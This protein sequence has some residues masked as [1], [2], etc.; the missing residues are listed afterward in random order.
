MRYTQKKMIS[1]MALTSVALFVVLAISGPV[2]GGD[3]SV[4]VHARGHAEVSETREIVLGGPLAEIKWAPVSSSLEL[5]SIRFALT[6]KAATPLPVSDVRVEDPCGGNRDTLLRRYVGK[7]I[8]LV[9]PETGDEVKGTLL[10]VDK[11]RPGMLKTADGSLHLNPSGE[12]VLPPDPNLVSQPILV[13]RFASP[14]EGKRGVQLTYRTGGLKWEPLYS[15]IFDEKTGKVDL[16]GTLILSNDTKIGFE[17]AAWRFFSTEKQKVDGPE[18]ARLDKVIEFLP[19][20]PADRQSLPARSTLRLPLL[21]ARNLPVAVAY[22]FDPLAS[23]PRVD[24][25]AQKLQR[26]IFVDN[27][28]ADN[29]LGLGGSLPSGKAKVVLRHL[30]GYTEPLGEQR[31]DSVS[32]GESVQVALGAAE[33]L[34]GKRS[35]TPF[36]ELADER[37]QEQVITIRLQNNTKSDVLA[38]VFEH[39]WGRWEIPATSSEYEQIDN[40][41]IRFVLPVP[42]TGE[43]EITYR[44]RI[45]Y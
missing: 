40:K 44:L 43:A 5:D 29:A 31:V 16:S 34:M 12:I 19:L 30:S 33:G 15:I 17:D 3:L 27:S 22:V 8:R 32:A 4:M 18:R 36:V 45:K 23:G 39:P 28:D 41:T 20:K 35:Q 9:R 37:A 1:S 13:G 2:L 10:T 24:T 26:V 7:E 11:G 42:A 21:D 14:L 38:T 6:G 25:P